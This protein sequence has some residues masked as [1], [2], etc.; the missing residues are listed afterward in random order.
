MIPHARLRPGPGFKL[1]RSCLYFAQRLVVLP[2]LRSAASKAIALALRLR[3]VKAMAG[4]TAHNL[5]AVSALR[6]DGI[7]MLPGLVT[8][9]QTDAWLAY[10][11]SQPVIAPD[12][13]AC[14]L[15]ALPHATAMAAH[16]MEVILRAPGL[17]DSLCHERVLAAV[18][19]YIGCRPTLSSLGVRWSFPNAHQA[20]DTQ[21][22]H[23]DPDDWRF[24]KLFIYLTDVDI[25]S[26]PHVYVAGSHRTRGRI[27]ARPYADDEVAAHSDARNVLEILGPAGT[28]FM[29]DTYGIHAGMVPRQSP[30]LIIQAQYSLLPVF[31]F[32]Y[33]PLSLP[34]LRNPDPYLLR[35]LLASGAAS[36]A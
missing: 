34:N 7:V 14:D 4:D 22:F 3:R 23:R 36:P 6:R 16:P 11:R 2:G 28:A 35:L 12:G 1:G 18:T 29:A 21:R 13:S 32:R 9:D 17:L 24:L 8:P 15:A 26:G 10:F 20:A 31:A 25:N 33:E 27:R 5:A 19:S 30:R